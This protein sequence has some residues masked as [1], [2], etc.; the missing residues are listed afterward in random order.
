ME[1]VKVH[2]AD[3][4][5]C[6]GTSSYVSAVVAPALLHSP[7]FASTPENSHSSQHWALNP[8]SLTDLGTGLLFPQLKVRI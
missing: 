7:K 1:T 5:P 4:L 8:T 3:T 6:K 2:S